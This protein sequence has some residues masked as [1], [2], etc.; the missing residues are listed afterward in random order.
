MFNFQGSCRHFRDSFL[1]L[2]QSLFTVNCFLI[3]F[4]KFFKNFFQCRFCGRICWLL[5]YNITFFEKV[6]YFFSSF[7]CTFFQICRLFNF[8]SKVPQHI[9]N[10][11]QYHHNFT[12][13]FFEA[14]WKKLK[15]TFFSKGNFVL[16]SQ[17]N[18]NFQKI[19]VGKPTL[20]LSFYLFYLI[21][22]INIRTTHTRTHA[23]D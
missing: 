23:H 8:S 10:Y 19:K 14:F 1:I 18:Q 2:T 6:C 22:L 11:V 13:N 12:P 5:D 15:H 20:I 17:K 21:I 3:N 16:F 9:V 7:I 4:Y